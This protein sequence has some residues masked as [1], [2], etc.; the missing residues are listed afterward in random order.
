M[1]VFNFNQY[2]DMFGTETLSGRNPWNSCC[3]CEDREGCTQ[4]KDCRIVAKK[5]NILKYFLKF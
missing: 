5:S 1:L 4:E 2:I 3:V